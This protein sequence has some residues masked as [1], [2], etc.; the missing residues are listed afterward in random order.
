MKMFLKK[1]RVSEIHIIIFVVL[2]I[3]IGFDVA[4]AKEITYT[5]M[6]NLPGL[7]GAGNIPE[8]INR[9]YIM[10]IAVGATFGVLKIAFAGVKYT[11]SDV[12]TSKQSALADIKGVLLGL[13]LLLIPALVL[14][15]IYPQLTSLDILKGLN[16]GS[17]GGGGGG[18]TES[19]QQLQNQINTDN[20]TITN[21]GGLSSTNY[22]EEG[23]LVCVPNGQGIPTQSCIPPQQLIN[24]ECDLPTSNTNTQTN[25]AINSEDSDAP[26]NEPDRCVLF[27]DCD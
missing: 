15:T 8:F 19:Q 4:H 20:Q 7:S 2:Y 17:S 26:T 23:N 13:A 18:L 1:R 21:C 5:P 22:D 16:G 6:T 12:V 9:V 11:M 10:L 3:L 14:N 25:T 24:G 27:N